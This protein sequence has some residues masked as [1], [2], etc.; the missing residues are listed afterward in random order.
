MTWI[1]SSCNGVTLWEARARK[2][3]DG[4]VI[5]IPCD[6]CGAKISSTVEDPDAIA[7]L[8][9]TASDFRGLSVELP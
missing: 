3:D 1:C 8:D 6:K 2:R 5:E 4:W 9:R 7:A